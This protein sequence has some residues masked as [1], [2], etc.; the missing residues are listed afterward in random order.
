LPLPANT[1][2]RGKRKAACGPRSN[3]KASAA[4]APAKDE[5][6]AN[7][8]AHPSS[9]SRLR[10]SP[11]RPD[12]PR[13]SVACAGETAAGGGDMEGEVGKVGEVGE[14][15]GGDGGDGTPVGL[16]G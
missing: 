10:P 7:T 2:D 11:K 9:A 14:V 3:C 4:V 5:L 6:L 1:K 8:C 16:G 12:L 15:G 13:S